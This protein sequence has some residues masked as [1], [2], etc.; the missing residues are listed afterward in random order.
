[1]AAL[2]TVQIPHT[3]SDSESPS[4]P[5]SLFPGDGHQVDDG[6]ACDDLTTEAVA[7]R[8]AKA[9]FSLSDSERIENK[10]VDPNYSPPA[11]LPL[12]RED[13]LGSNWTWLG[14]VDRFELVK[15]C[16]RSRRLF[17]QSGNGGCESSV[18]PFEWRDLS[19]SELS[20]VVS[21]HEVGERL[22]LQARPA[23]A[24]LLFE[25]ILD[26]S[27]SDVLANLKL[28]LAL[29]AADAQSGGSG[30]VSGAAGASATA[31]RLHVPALLRHAVAL[32]PANN[33][34]IG[35]VDL[36]LRIISR[37]AIP[38]QLWGASDFPRSS[39][40]DLCLLAMLRR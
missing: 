38:D 1:M 14:Q 9:K 28:A 21:C 11:L 7:L 29:L 12:H 24:A 22:L 40:M 39:G 10:L 36:I 27:P 17:R 13:E 18:E 20:W 15:S 6:S 32:D 8:R 16:K 23:E 25:A 30:H 5:P 19:D 31:R 33:H 2:T 3:S 26:L 34:L 37:T 4:S 35:L